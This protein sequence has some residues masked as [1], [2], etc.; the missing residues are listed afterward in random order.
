M[1][2]FP[3]VSLLICPVCL[4]IP[5]HWSSSIYPVVRYL[6][7]PSSKTVLCWLE[8]RLS[9]GIWLSYNTVECLYPGLQWF[10]RYRPSRY[11]LSNCHLAAS[12]LRNPA[13]VFED[14]TVLHWKCPIRTRFHL[15]I[16]WYQKAFSDVW[17]FRGQWW[18]SWAGLLGALRDRLVC[19]FQIL[20]LAFLALAAWLN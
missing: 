14:F 19:H 15:G 6:G 16:S 20:I 7:S 11:V 4:L 13:L 10:L 17:A 8:S 3:L 5:P 12:D 2:W 1:H 18:V 9:L